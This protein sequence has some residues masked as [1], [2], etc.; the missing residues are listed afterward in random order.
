MLCY[1]GAYPRR[2]PIRIRENRF[3]GKTLFFPLFVLE[4][5][6]ISLKQKEEVAVHTLLFSR[7]RQVGGTTIRVF[8]VAVLS[9]VGSNAAP[10]TKVQSIRSKKIVS[11]G[12]Y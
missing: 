4:A 10:A 3:R 11:F 5:E 9:I 12:T 6:S 7:A 1:S 8:A 2:L